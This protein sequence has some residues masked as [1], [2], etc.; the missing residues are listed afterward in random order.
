M[1]AAAALIE[2][3]LA[4]PLTVPEIARTV[5]VSHDH[6]TRLFRSATG[7]TVVGRIR[8]RRMERA[9]HFP[10]ATTMSIPAIAVSV[11]IH[12]LRAFSKA[13]RRELGAAPRAV[14]AAQSLVTG[15]PGAPAPVGRQVGRAGSKVERAAGSQ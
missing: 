12:D 14:R 11:G 3:R 8:A 1:A 5:G 13:C 6:P 4:Q 15:S 2:A 10:R 7:E 9:R